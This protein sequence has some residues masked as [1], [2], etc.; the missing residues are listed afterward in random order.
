MPDIVL[1]YTNFKSLVTAKGLLPQYADNGN[2]YNV[3][4]IESNILWEC[5]VV[6]DGGSDQTDFETNYRSTCNANL[7]GQATMAVSSPVVIASNQTTLPAT[8][9]NTTGK[10]VVMLTGNYQSVSTTANQVILT[11]TVTAGHTFFMEYFAFRGTPY[12]PATNAASGMASLESPAGVK[13]YTIRCVEG[14]GGPNGQTLSEPIPFPAGTVVR[15]VCTPISAT[16]VTWF[17]NFGGFER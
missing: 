5:F 16:Q 17:A 15:V 2:Q 4:A 11:Y 9:G 10:T 8:L 14:D 13:L 6:K 12:A 1:T 3:F 7:S